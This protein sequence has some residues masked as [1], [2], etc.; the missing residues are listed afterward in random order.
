LAGNL[1]GVRGSVDRTDR[2]L[3]RSGQSF[4]FGYRCNTRCNGETS[5]DSNG[6]IFSGQTKWTYTE[7]IS[8]AGRILS[9]EIT[10][11]TW[12]ALGRNN[13]AWEWRSLAD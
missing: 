9:F 3:H 2:S 10:E 11:D 1:D 6:K 12:N 13:L 4:Q 7:Y 5:R 8:S